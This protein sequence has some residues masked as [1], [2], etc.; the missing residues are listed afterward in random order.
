ML[1]QLWN[2]KANQISSLPIFSFQQQQS[3][4]YLSKIWCKIARRNLRLQLN[5]R[6][7]NFTI[8]VRQKLF[9]QHR[10]ATRRSTSSTH[11]YCQKNTHTHKID[12]WTR[13]TKIQATTDAR[14]SAWY[15]DAV[16]NFINLYKYDKSLYDFSRRA[17]ERE[18]EKDWERERE[19][20]QAGMAPCWYGNRKA[21]GQERC[22]PE[23]AD[24]QEA[25]YIQLK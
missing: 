24:T 13:D 19:A 3:L 17:R 25:L 22:Q 10:H 14:S 4:I 23:A 12:T 18:R 21:A 6:A 8:Q 7:K 20:T 2:F 5:Y 16:Y 11:T 9:A 15:D 1:N